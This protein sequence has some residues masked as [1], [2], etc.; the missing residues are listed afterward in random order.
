MEK[1]LCVELKI[2]D[3][4]VEVFLLIE[5]MIYL[6]KLVDFDE[7]VEGFKDV[8][9]MF[10]KVCDNVRVVFNSDGFLIVE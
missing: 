10:E 9:K 8:W 1:I 6:L 5:I 3:I 4:F 2:N 7:V